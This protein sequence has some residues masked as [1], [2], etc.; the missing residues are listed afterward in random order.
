MGIRVVVGIMLLV[1]A[2]VFAVNVMSDSGSSGGTTPDTSVG[3]GGGT[4]PDYSIQ[5]SCE[6]IR[7]DYM[8]ADPGSAEERWALE[9]AEEV[10][11]SQ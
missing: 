2:G 5:Q 9:A 10:C 6:E 7:A 3:G 8:S 4:Q 11:F 1:L